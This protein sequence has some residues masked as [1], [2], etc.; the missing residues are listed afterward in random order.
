[1]AGFRNRQEAG[2]ALAK[3]VAE[4]HLA[5]AVVLG[6]PRGG[7]PVAAEVA[8]RI[9][10]P[11]D[12]I[13]VRKLGVPGN[14]ELGMGAIAEDGV[15]VFNDQVMEWAH[16]DTFEVQ[17][18]IGVER[19]NLLDRTDLIRATVEKL[20]L[21][22]KTAV[23]VDD[24]IATGIDALAACRAARLRGAR[25][26]VL[27]APV[28][29]EGWERRLEGEANDFVAVLVAADFMSVG[30]FYEEFEPVSDTEML[31]FFDVRT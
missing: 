27:A 9:S 8:R 10:A 26:V 13:V 30:Q 25:R 1:M 12:V 24:G 11:L 20:D 29:P 15:V 23:V 16:V 14:V 21:T 6:L 19:R 18:A 31:G 17:S 22:G 7:V 28:A 5:D 2:I 3:R 4:L